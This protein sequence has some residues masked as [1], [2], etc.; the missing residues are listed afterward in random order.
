M[1]DFIGG[2]PGEIRA[3]YSSLGEIA[4]IFSTESEDVGKLTQRIRQNVDQL[5]GGGWKST[6]AD[7]FYNEMDSIIFPALKR[8]KAALQQGSQVSQQLA[9]LLQQA[10]EEA[11]G[12]FK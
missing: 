11:S 2:G 7:R 5:R 8:L 1:G 9:Q 12:L 10:E 3:D 6:G 4:K